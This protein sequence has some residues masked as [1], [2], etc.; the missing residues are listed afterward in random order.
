M[1]LQH[2]IYLPVLL[3]LLP[4]GVF[5]KT[6]TPATKA[7]SHPP[8]PLEVSGWIPY[9]R[10]AT[11]TA[12][13]IAHIDSFTE[14]S[15]FGYTVRRDGT[16]FDAMHI[17]AGPWQTLVQTAH[18][19]KVRVIPTVMWS[20]ADAIDM[21]LRSPDLRKAHIKEIVQV[22]RVHGFDGI[23]IDYEAKKAATKNYFSLFLRDLYHAI[24]NKFV[25]C[26]IEPRT[27]LDSRF[28]EI[29][30]SIQYANDFTAINKYCDR[31]RIMAYDQG[32]IDLK[33]NAA[34]AGPY[35]P[36]AD[37]QWVEKVVRL[38]AKTIAKKKIVIGVPT[39][40]YEFAVTPL[41]QGYMYKLKWALDPKYGL[42]LAGEFGLTPQRNTA[43]ELSFRY[44]PTTTSATPDSGNALSSNNTL[45]TT[46]AIIAPTAATSTI[47]NAP[48]RLVWWSDAHAVRDKVLLAKK[49]G[50]RGI[51]IF[52]ID[53][54]EDPAI[55]SMLK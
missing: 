4:F 12:D 19:H 32:I 8:I 27:P 30:K 31:V 1:K 11:G 29:P 25:V 6:A 38:A 49:L 42:N 10:T 15:P 35:A 33:L 51:A 37:P 36:V 26:S 13:A 17:D 22:V 43:G 21:I 55:W 2:K 20:N 46:T 23:D 16:L 44:V 48:F 9:W 28:S 47:S 52:K 5:A 40:G 45:A 34:T 54:G 3:T 7:R 18:S 14:V 39:Y 53:G 50:V 24:G 41:T